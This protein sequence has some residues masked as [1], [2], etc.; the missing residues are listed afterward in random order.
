MA[1]KTENKTIYLNQGELYYSDK[2]AIVRTLLGSCVSVTFYNKRTHY[3]GIIHAMYP[4]YKPESDENPLLYVDY[5]IRRLIENFSEKDI[6]PEEIEVK[7]F[8]GGDVI[9]IKRENHS[10][11]YKNVLSALNTLKEFNLAITSVDVRND[12]GRLLYFHTDSG[13]IYL[14]KIQ[15]S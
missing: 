2:P 5:A 9:K 7:L 13:K 12:F 4:E 11:G 15:S 3:A 10:I 1:S 14:K 6:N 8:G